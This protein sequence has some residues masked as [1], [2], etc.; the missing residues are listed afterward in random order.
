MALASVDLGGILVERQIP[1]ESHR[2]PQAVLARIAALVKKMAPE[3]VQA[4]GFGVP[5]LLNL[6]DGATLFLT[7]FSTQWRNLAVVSIL[8]TALACAVYLLNDACMATLGGLAL[9][10]RR[11]MI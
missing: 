4:F 7:N 10:R 5:G 2:G 9:A 6:K 11:G 1:T 8:E 3:G